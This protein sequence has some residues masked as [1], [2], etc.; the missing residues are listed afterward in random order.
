M[1]VSYILHTFRNR[2]FLGMN[3]ELELGVHVFGIMWNYILEF[4]RYAP[5]SIIF[6]L[7]GEV[8][9]HDI[10]SRFTPRVFS[11]VVRNFF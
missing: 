9:V 2:Y 8:G 5:S 3:R 11:L 6:Y 4:I 10:K 1:K 7:Q